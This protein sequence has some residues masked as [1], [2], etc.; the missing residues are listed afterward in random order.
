MKVVLFSDTCR[1]CLYCMM[2]EADKVVSMILNVRVQHDH[3][4]CDDDDDD[5]DDNDD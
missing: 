3:F 1:M 2:C 4:R 5:D